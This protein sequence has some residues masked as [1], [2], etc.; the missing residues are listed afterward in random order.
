M[1][2]L[3]PR[4]GT[5]SQRTTTAELF[6]DLVYVFAITQLSHLLLDHL[7]FG[8]AAQA[9]FLLLVVWWA[10][11]Y[12]T[13]MTNWFDPNS[14]SVRFVLTGA[15]LASLLLAASLPQAFGENGLLFAAA[16]VVLQVGRNFAA[17]SLLERDHRLR[18]VYQRVLLWSIAS[19]ALWLAGAA[20]DSDHRLSLWLPALLLDLLAPVAGYWLPGRG[21]ATTSDYDIEG[22]HFTERCQLFILIALGESIVVAGG[23]AADGG[24]TPTTLVSLAVAFLETAALWWLYFGTPAEQLRAAVISSENPGRLARDAYTYAHVLI[25][26]GIVATAAAN[27]LLLAA[28]REPAH[29]T[30]LAVLLGGPALYLL[31]LGLFQW[32]TTGRFVKKAVVGAALV[33]ASIPFGHHLPVLA[34]A[35]AMTLLLAALAVWELGSWRAERSRSLDRGWTSDPS[36]EGSQRGAGVRPGSGRHRRAASVR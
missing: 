5:E 17:M 3:R 13:W 28:P 34:L 31:G 24:L 21:R 18:D 19:G 27:N 7:S 2:H 4:D 11:I 23:T 14:P 8:S 30:D 25:V 15:M 16:Y 33:I 10:W 35:S 20:L 6:F 32:M 22:G 29:G 1:T 36:S 12:T 26:G 9:T